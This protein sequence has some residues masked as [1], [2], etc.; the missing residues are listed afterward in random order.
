MRKGGWVFKG[1]HSTQVLGE[2]RS[3]V[4]NTVCP[5]RTAL[6]KS[7]LQKA[8]LQAFVTVCDHFSSVP[9]NFSL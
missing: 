9:K 8:G 1:E 7:W 3:H 2:P 4:H 6:S 5:E